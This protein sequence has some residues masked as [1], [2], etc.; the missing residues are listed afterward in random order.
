MKPM[1]IEDEEIQDAIQQAARAACEVL[2]ETFPGH[3][4]NKPGIT[5]NFQGLLVEILV[6]MLAGNDPVSRGSATRL[7]RLVFTDRSF[8][9]C[10]QRSEDGY[11]VLKPKAAAPRY[12]SPMN[13]PDPE[14]ELVLNDMGTR[15]IPIDTPD[16]IDPFTSFEA[17]V[18][19]AMDY[20]KREGEIDFMPEVRAVRMTDT[21]YVLAEQTTAGNEQAHAEYCNVFS[22]SNT[23]MAALK[24]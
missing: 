15:F 21:G 7:P 17:A 18:K 4:G 11:V 5:S 8:G 2:D 9:D 10:R 19:A 24:Q 22:L 13:P 16:A 1:H 20:M 14:P 3:D 6:Q 12:F 23:E